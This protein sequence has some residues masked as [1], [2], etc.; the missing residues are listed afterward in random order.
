MPSLR[1]SL[2]Y[3]EP[4][5]A[6]DIDTDFDVTTEIPKGADPDSRS[7]T[8]RAYHQSLWSKALP[9]GQRFILD[10]SGP[11]PTLVHYSELGRF[12][13][14]SDAITNSYRHT[15][16]AAR[17]MNEVR[18]EADRL[19]QRGCTVAAYTIW[20]ANTIAN[21]TINKAR[22]LLRKIGDRMDLTLECLRLF[23]AGI[24]D[25]ER[26]PLGPTFLNYADFFA[27]FES[28]EGYIEFFLLQDI[29]NDGA[30]RFWLPFEGFDGDPRPKTAMEYR[31]Y[32]SVV[33]QFIDLRAQ[34]MR[35]QVQYATQM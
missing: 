15:K 25:A 4:M 23:Y 35:D 21:T 34:R 13:L 19:Y 14:A 33:L 27:L 29:V 20:P 22:G 9:N 7:P 16:L 1:P 10:I 30:V 3:T 28:F 31:E 26:N 5:T 12:V 6:I 8:L 18:S 24:T 2:V 17:Y 11:A 32:A